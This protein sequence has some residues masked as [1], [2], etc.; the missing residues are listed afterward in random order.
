MKERPQLV[1][2]YCAELHKAT[3]SMCKYHLTGYIDGRLFRYRNGERQPR[4]LD[5][6]HDEWR[7]AHHGNR[8]ARKF[9][10]EN[11]N[12]GL[13]FVNSDGVLSNP[14]PYVSF[15]EFYLKKRSLLDNK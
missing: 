11:W 12:N 3:K 10:T 15:S 2:L 4:E 9:A 5:L 6:D 13:F 1:R 7:C 14:V 8:I